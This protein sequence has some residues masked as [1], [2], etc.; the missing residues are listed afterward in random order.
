MH[1]SWDLFNFTLII[2]VVLTLD[3]LSLSNTEK[4]GPVKADYKDALRYWDA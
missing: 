3:L 1:V 2:E 4:T